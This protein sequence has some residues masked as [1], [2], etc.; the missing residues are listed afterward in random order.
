MAKQ[1]F[2]NLPVLDLKKSKEFYKKI[3]FKFNEKYTDEKAVCVIIGKNIFA[4]LLVKEFFKNFTKKQIINA[5]NEAEVIL[6]ITV[7]SKKKIDAIVVKALKAG[8]TLAREAQ[9]LG[10]MYS[11]SIEDLDGHIWEL[12]WMNEKKLTAEIKKNKKSKK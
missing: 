9:D 5:K 6:A 2:V 4:M 11:Q 3:G 7:E 12:F 8:G 1:I 10:Y